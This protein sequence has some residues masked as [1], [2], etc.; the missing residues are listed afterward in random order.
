MNNNGQ[1]IIW[2]RNP[3]LISAERYTY[4]TDFWST[5]E[6]YKYGRGNKCILT[7]FSI[8]PK[9]S[10]IIIILHHPTPQTAAVNKIPSMCYSHSSVTFDMKFHPHYIA[11]IKMSVH[12]SRKL[13]KIFLFRE[14]GGWK[15]LLVSH[16]HQI[17]DVKRPSGGV[18]HTHSVFLYYY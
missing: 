11:T 13:I 9:I 3:S 17:L 7:L 1:L 8:L 4:L 10:P 18:I 15:W 6:N 2:G 12:H 14:G 16:R 5:R